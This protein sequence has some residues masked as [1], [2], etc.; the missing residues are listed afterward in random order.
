MVSFYDLCVNFSVLVNLKIRELTSQRAQNLVWKVVGP[1][2]NSSW[3]I[4]YPWLLHSRVVVSL[5]RNSVLRLRSN[6]TSKEAHKQENKNIRN[7][8]SASCAVN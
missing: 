2:L 7:V 8:V 3:H 4:S 5:E 6:L 1:S